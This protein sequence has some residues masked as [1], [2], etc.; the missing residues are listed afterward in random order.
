MNIRKILCLCLAMLLC[1]AGALLSQ[2]MDVKRLVLL[3]DWA[4]LLDTV[5]VVVFAAVVLTAVTTVLNL[6]AVIHKRR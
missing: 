4:A 3:G 6:L 5:D 2:L 1:C